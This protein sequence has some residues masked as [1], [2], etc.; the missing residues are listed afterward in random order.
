M[1]TRSSISIKNENGTYTS[2]YCHNDGYPSWNGR[3]LY[4]FYK[5]PDQIQKLLA[6]GDM[7]VLGSKLEPENP[8]THSFDTPE[9]D[10]C[11]FYH[12]DRGEDWSNVKPTQCK[13]IKDIIDKMGGSYD[14][15]FENNNWYMYDGNKRMLLVDILRCPE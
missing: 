4:D 14:Y 2:V 5:T 10:T 15:I 6:F 3:I 1:S 9:S 12:R 13:S 7:S 11:V 8:K